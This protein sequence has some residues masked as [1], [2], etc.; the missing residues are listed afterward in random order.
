VGLRADDLDSLTTVA[1]AATAEGETIHAMPFEVRSADVVSALA[2]IERFSR[3]VRR[4]AGLPDPVPYTA[5]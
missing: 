4:E 5:H 3:R 1:D 2:S